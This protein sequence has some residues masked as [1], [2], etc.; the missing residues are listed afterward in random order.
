MEYQ[1]L[2]GLEASKQWD[3][4]IKDLMH[5]LK[6][7]I[8][9]QPK[10]QWH[11]GN[12]IYKVLQPFGSVVPGDNILLDSYTHNMVV[13]LATPTEKQVFCDWS[14]D[15]GPRMKFT[16]E[17][18]NNKLRPLTTREIYNLLPHMSDRIKHLR[19]YFLF[20]KSLPEFMCTPCSEQF[21]IEV[22][23]GWEK[24]KFQRRCN[25]CG[26]NKVIVRPRNAFKPI[27]R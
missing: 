12:G 14:E 19:G 25:C 27:G 5:R 26:K 21:Q 4:A 10:Q 1:I 15:F 17:E 13:K 6:N 22:N 7:P 11:Y 23:K 16:P 9:D 2:M 18:W 24:H 8:L 3:G 20:A